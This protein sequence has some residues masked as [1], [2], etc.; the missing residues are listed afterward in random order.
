MQQE[1]QAQLAQ[2]AIDAP[3]VI[4][5]ASWQP[6]DAIAPDAVQAEQRKERGL[7]A[8]SLVD[9]AIMLVIILLLSIPLLG[10]FLYADGVFN[11]PFGAAA[12]QQGL[13]D[14]ATS[15]QT[16]PSRFFAAFV[17]QSLGMAGIVA[18]RVRLL[19]RLPWAWLGVTLQ[20]FGRNLAFGVGLGALTFVANLA[21]GAIF[22]RLGQRSNQSDLFPIRAGDWGGA[23]LVFIAGAILAPIVEELFFRGYV[24]KAWL[25]RWGAPT[26]YLVSAAIF[27]VPHL[28]GITQGQWSLLIPIFLIGLLFAWGFHRTRSLVPAIV[29]HAINN[30]IGLAALIIEKNTGG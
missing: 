7:W 10:Y 27:A 26:A 6:N 30:G 18:L 12:F 16:T 13:L 20:R 23:A 5:P 25:V 2:P 1:P 17:A 21:L 24:F 22:E 4:P 14:T 8:W 15:L 28:A 19:R 3:P 11:Q 29:A 9:G